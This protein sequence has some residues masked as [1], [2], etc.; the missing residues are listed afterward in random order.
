MI[1]HYPQTLRIRSI[2]HLCI[3]LGIN[4][5]VLSKVTDNIDSYYREFTRDIKGKTRHLIEA[6]GLLKT[7]QKRVLNRLLSRLPPFENSFGSI[8]GKSIKQNALQHAKS[9]YIIKLD[10]RDFY[11]SI[12]RK[13]VYNFFIDEECSPDVARIL[14]ILT[15]RKHYLPLGTSTSPMLAD[16][17]VRKIDKR[18]NAMTQK[19]SLMYTRYVDDITISGNHPLD[20]IIPSVVKILN[21]SGFRVKKE[22]LIKYGPEVKEKIITGVSII[23]GRITAPLNAILELETSL[24]KAII[25]SRKDTIDFVFEQRQHYRGKIG[26]V[27]WLDPKKGNQL[28]KLYRKVK[29]QHLE[30]LM[31]N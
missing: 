1:N 14:T 25:E 31:A 12:H 21:Q 4:K 23:D 26:Y 16:Q 13:K 24:K 9:K 8:K 22:K 29:W 6:K 18:L 10:I 19:M 30:W 5:G 17:I 28:L 7:I 3:I 2:K 27:Y 15:T 11:P 20:S